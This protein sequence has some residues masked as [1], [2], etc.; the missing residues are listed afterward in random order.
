[1]ISRV[2]RAHRDHTQEVE[3]LR[4]VERTAVRG[5]DPGVAPLRIGLSPDEQTRART[6]VIASHAA[7]MAGW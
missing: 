4:L 6:S 7:Y 5:D 1:M 2:V 3:A